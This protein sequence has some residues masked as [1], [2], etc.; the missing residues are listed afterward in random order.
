MKRVIFFGLTT[1]TFGM[2]AL[3][4]E[5]IRYEP[6][7]NT[8]TKYRTVTQSTGEVI[9][10][11]LVTSDGQPAPKA[12]ENLLESL[13]AGLNT[14]QTQEI[15]EKVVAIDAAGTRQLETTV[16]SKSSQAT[17][18][19]GFEMRSSMTPEGVLNVSSF[20]F[21]ATTQAQPGIAALGNSFTELMRDAFSQQF[22]NIYGKTLELGQTL[23]FPVLN[24]AE[25]FI[26]AFKAV[27]IAK[28]QVEGMQGNLNYT[29][30]GRNL[31]SDYTFKIISSTNPGKFLVELPNYSLEQRLTDSRAEGEATYFTDGRAKTSSQNANQTLTQIQKISLGQQTL[32][33]TFSTR[34]KT[35]STTE[36]VQ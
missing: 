15:T 8:I 23:T 36:I 20:Q 9:T 34:T 14:T 18:P 29:Y 31:T 5:T 16:M 33:I 4:A 28:I 35:V 22:P 30:Q 32:T 7:L 12:F 6:A 25:N 27:P 17:Q 21:D 24:F 11:S 10:S 1:L 3:A 13:K 19:I 26:R 2:I